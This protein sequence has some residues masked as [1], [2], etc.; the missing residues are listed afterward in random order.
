MENDILIVLAEKG[1]WMKICKPKQKHGA[2]CGCLAPK[3]PER[4]S[5][6]SLRSVNDSKRFLYKE[7]QKQYTCR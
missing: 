2:S 4:H 6:T 1:V 7:S 5:F 3:A